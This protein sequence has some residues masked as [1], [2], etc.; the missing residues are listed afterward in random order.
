MAQLK[1]TTINGGLTV[2]SGGAGVELF[3]STPYIDFHY[4]NNS[5]DYTSRII[6]SASGVLNIQATDL[7][8][9]GDSLGKPN[10]LFHETKNQAVV[11]VVYD[12]SSDGATTYWYLRPETD[13]APTSRLGTNSTRWNYIYADNG[14]F[15][16]NV[17]ANNFTVPNGYSYRCKGSGG[18]NIATM[19][20]TTSNN[21]QIGHPTASSAHSGDTQVNATNGD[22]HLK[23]ALG[24]VTWR[25]LAD[26]ASGYSGIFRPSTD[27]LALL[28]STD[29]RWKKLVAGTSTIATSDRREKS[30]ITPIADYPVVFSNNTEGNVFEQLFDKLN[31]TTYYFNDDA[32]PELHIGFIAQDIVEAAKE[33]GMSEDDLAFIDHGFWTDKETGE[34]RD[35]YGLAYEEFIALNTYVIQRQKEKINTL[36]ERIAKLEKLI[37]A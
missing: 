20:I 9:N 37:N 24:T 26:S 11:R 6:E 5:G 8:L 35:R 36:E 10:T 3:G 7:K 1:D 25:N 34:E 2:K 12:T 27:N 21:L 29:C 33:L 19:Y 16:N 15:T 31:P 13:I 32:K 28:G 30:D 18:A 23:N 22:V 14:V 4:N 17:S